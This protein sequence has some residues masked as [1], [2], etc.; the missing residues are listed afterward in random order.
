M[1]GPRC[2]ARVDWVVGR[3]AAKQGGYGVDAYVGA[4]EEREGGR[5]P[6]D[7]ITCGDQYFFDGDVFGRTFLQFI[8]IFF[9]SCSPPPPECPPE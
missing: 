1:A 6:E 5:E 2:E 8:T 9:R 7:M 3:E 4:E